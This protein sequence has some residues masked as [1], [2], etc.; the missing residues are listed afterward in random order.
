MALSRNPTRTRRIEKRWLKEI[1]R[2]WRA[3]TASITTELPT[4]HTNAIETD[5][6]RVAAYMEFVQR[7]IEELL[8]GSPQPPNWQAVYQLQA[9]NQ[10]VARAAETLKRQ[11]VDAGLASIATFEPELIA[12]FGATIRHSAELE[13]LFT[14]SYES[15]NGWTDALAREIR[16]IITDGVREGKGIAELTGDIRK[17]ANVSKSRAQLIARTET[18]QAH[19]RGTISE[20][21]AISAATGEEIALRWV[22]ANDSR[23]RHLHAGWHGD[24][25]SGEE[26]FR[27]INVSPFNCRCAQ[28]P[29][30]P[31]L[32]TKKRVEKFKREREMLLE[33]QKVA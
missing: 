31:E 17:R 9:F 28:A 19:Q 24:L 29:V 14:R 15:L 13:Q 18:I 5:P 2:R 26:S 21:E 12:A 30:I 20:T 10:A 27:R 33:Q 22:T 8:L 3:F 1:N 11:G 16:S 23:V 25:I 32:D 4:I 6:A 7:R